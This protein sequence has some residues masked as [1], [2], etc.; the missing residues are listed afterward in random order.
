MQSNVGQN[1]QSEYKLESRGFWS[2]LKK[3]AK[4]ATSIVTSIGK[5]NNL[6]VAL[7]GSGGY[8]YGGYNNYGKK[9]KNIK[10]TIAGSS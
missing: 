7:G 10:T 4:A 9:W 8:G 1:I 3:Y 5:Y 2:S 6:G